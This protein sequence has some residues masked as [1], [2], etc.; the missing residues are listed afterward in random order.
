MTGT[1]ISWAGPGEWATFLPFF[2][3]LSSGLW[4]FVC[5]QMT[6]GMPTRKFGAARSGMISIHPLLFQQS[7]GVHWLLNGIIS[8]N[9]LPKGSPA[10]SFPDIPPFLPGFPT[11]LLPTS[12]SSSF[13]PS[14]PFPLPPPL[15]L[16]PSSFLSFEYELGVP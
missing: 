13:V 12:S 3:L 2:L 6:K 16:P 14:S 11:S 1:A 8:F 5:P 9:S 10:I 4:Q 7:H 15:P